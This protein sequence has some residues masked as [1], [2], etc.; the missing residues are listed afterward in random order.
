MYEFDASSGACAFGRNK[1]VFKDKH[2]SGQRHPMSKIRPYSGQMRLISKH[3][4]SRTNTPCFEHISLLSLMSKR[5]TVNLTV[6]LVVRLA[7]TMIEF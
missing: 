5:R 4:L 3:A 6:K 2:H 1:P 7:N